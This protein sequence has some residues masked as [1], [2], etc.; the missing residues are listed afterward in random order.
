MI[1]SLGEVHR[2]VFSS[3]KLLNMI[4]LCRNPNN[5][6]APFTGAHIKILHTSFC[7]LLFPAWGTSISDITHSLGPD[8]VREKVGK[9]IQ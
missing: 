4:G 2:D 7:T 3:W 9:I 6:Q 8:A 5:S 1:T